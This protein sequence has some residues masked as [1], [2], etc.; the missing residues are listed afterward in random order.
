M[1]SI[2]ILHEYAVGEVWS[3]YVDRLSENFVGNGMD[4]DADA[5][6]RREVLL[7]NCGTQTYAL[8]NELLAP[9]KRNEKSFDELAK[10]VAEH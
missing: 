7:A 1:A 2:R 5:A 8:I 3:D 9:V 6:R 10:L 4:G